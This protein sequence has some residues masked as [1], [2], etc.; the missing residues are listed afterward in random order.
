MSTASNILRFA[1]MR[2]AAAAAF[3]VTFMGA[4]RNAFAQ[5][6][7]HVPT[8]VLSGHLAFAV[9]DP[10]GDFGKNTGNGY[11]VDAG[12]LWR[13]EKQGI[14][15]LRL[16][17]SFLSYASSTRRIPLAGSGNLIKLDL[18]TS[19]SIFSLVG[20]PQFLGPKGVF[21]PY[22]APLGGFSYFS[23]RTSVEGSDNDNDDFAS[24]TN[25]SDAVLTYGGAAGAYVR[26]YKSEKSDIRLELGGRYL[27]HDNAR[28]LNDQRVEEGY[29]N[30]RDPLPIRGRADFVTY[31]IGLN[32]IL[33]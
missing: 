30:N 29:Q 2:G 24:T 33:W 13:L 9:S 27:R 25:A 19:S 15:N 10:R 11:G 5:Q 16:D 31:Y 6:Q 7:E 18:K 23:T 32:A 4:S 26:V 21:T 20:G 14:L 22:V 28:Y 17:G 1:V 8:G 3:A 12:L